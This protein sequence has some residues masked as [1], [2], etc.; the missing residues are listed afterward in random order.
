LSRDYGIQPWQM[1]DLTIDE[2]DAIGR[3]LARRARAVK[4]AKRGR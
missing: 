4:E 2:Y 1:R 3:D